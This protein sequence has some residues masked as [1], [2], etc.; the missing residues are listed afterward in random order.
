MI[1]AGLGTQV[2]GSVVRPASYCG[3]YGFKPSV[4][5]L[6]REGCHD[7]QSQSCTGIIAAT[8]EDTWQVAHEIV[9][10]VGGDAG[11]P[12]LVGPD[13]C[14]APAKPT[15]LAFLETAGWTSAEPAAQKLMQGALNALRSAGIA[16]GTRQDDPMI[17]AVETNIVGAHPLSNKINSFEGRWFLRGARDRDVEKLSKA[18]QTRLAEAEPIT[19]ADHRAA[20]I[21]RAR[22]RAL[23]AELAASYDGCITLAA[24]GGAPKGLQS[25]G[26]SPFAVAGSLLGVP[27][28]TLPLFDIDGMPLGLQVLGFFNEDAKAFAISGWLRDQLS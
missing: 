8:L 24:T 12:G 28:L 20:L 13:T 4:N 22:I 18:M 27:A 5:A 10:R 15:R 25:T 6:N 3:A 16:I 11:T 21:E 1:S 14:P 2:I 17:A 26:N 19:L 9:S 23:Y 7:Y